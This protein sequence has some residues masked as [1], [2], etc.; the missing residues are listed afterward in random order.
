MNLGQACDPDKTSARWSPL[1]GR[2]ARKVRL[3]RGA[4]RPVYAPPP[5][6][7]HL[8]ALLM[9]IERL[10]E[11]TPTRLAEC[12]VISLRRAGQSL[13]TLLRQGRLRRRM[14]R[15]D[16]AYLYSVRPGIVVR[17]V[18]DTGIDSRKY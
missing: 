9:T 1:R 6:E 18:F 13:A 17:Q 15:S 14:R 3:W 7:A 12:A 8:Y 5:L 10:G 11:C 2:D 16:R 4:P